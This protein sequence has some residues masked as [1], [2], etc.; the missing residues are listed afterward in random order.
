MNCKVTAKSGCG[1]LSQVLLCHHLSMQS[2]CATLNL[3][4]QNTGYYF[5]FTI[6]T[7]ELQNKGNGQVHTLFK[8][9]CSIFFPLT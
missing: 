3:K 7:L 4:P 2:C 6:S 1:F 5:L 9:N 8:L